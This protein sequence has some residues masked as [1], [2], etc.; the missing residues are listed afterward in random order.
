MANTLFVG[1]LPYETTQEELERLFSTCGKVAS[2]KLIMD[3]DTGRS[4][5]FGFVEMST[6]A[7]AQASISKLN[8]STLGDRKIFINEAR[9]QEPRPAHGGF[10]D[11]P[12]FVERRSGVKDRRSQGPSGGFGGEKKWDSKPAGFG[13]EK[14]WGPKPGGFGGEKKWGSKPGGF[15]DKKKWGPK[16]GGFGGE[17][18]WDSKP[19]GFGGEKK[20][21]PKP[22]GFGAKKKWGPKPGGFGG[23]KKFGDK[24]GG[25]GGKGKRGGFGGGRP[26][27][28]GYR[29]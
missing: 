19:G 23:E 14:K 8:G 24:R 9:P 27:G 13:G 20:W 2:A 22:G 25:F 11:K 1:G 17:K 3:R 16:P 21:G 7:E 12:D 5:G 15:G 28:G 4:K 29:D 10:A 6:A 26:E 18:K